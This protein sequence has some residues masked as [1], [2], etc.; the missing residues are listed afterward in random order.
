MVLVA[1]G[2]STLLSCAEVEPQKEVGAGPDADTDADTD[3][4]TDVDTDTDGDT[5]TDTDGDTDSDTDG[6]TDTDTDT[7]PTTCIDEGDCGGDPCVDGF[8]CDGPCDGACQACDLEGF[9]GVCSFV[10][11]G[12]DPDDE[13]LEED[14]STCGTSGACDG[15]GACAFWGSETACDDEEPCTEDDACDGEGGC[16]GLTPAECDP[17]P[18]NECCEG[19]CSSISGCY[20]EV[21]E[22]VDV[23][24]SSALIVSQ[25]CVGCGAANAEGVCTGGTNYPCSSSSHTLCQERD[26]GGATYYCT[27]DGGTWGWRTAVACDDGDDCTYSDSCFGG[28][29]VSTAYTCDSDDCMDREC[30]GSGGC[31]ETP[32]ADTVECGTTSCPGDECSDGD[33][34]DYGEQCTNHCDGIGGCETCVCTPGETECLVGFS[35]ECCEVACSATGGCYTVAGSCGGGDIC[36]DSNTLIVGS[37]CTGCG[38]NGASGTCGGG[39]S[40]E[41]SAAT[42]TACE[43]VSC[44]GTTY[45]C[46]NVGG[47]WQWRSATSCDDGDPCTHGDVC[48]A[49]GCAGTGITC[50]DTVCMDRECNGTSSCTETPLPSSTECGTTA[51]PGDSCGVG[52]WYDYPSE[53]TSYCDGSGACDYCTCSSSATTCEVGSSNECCQVTCDAALGCGTT[54]GSCA[55]TDVCTDSNTLVYGNTCVGCGLNGANGV[56]GSGTTAT[57]NSTTH[58]LCQEVSCGG[59]NYYCTNVGGIWQWRISSSCDDSNLC[60]YSD[61]CG[62]T[63]ICS[64]TSITCADSS[65]GCVVRSCNGGSSC[66]QTFPSGNACV[67]SDLCTYDT[68]C[69]GAGVCAGG[70]TVDCDALDTQ[71]ADYF[72]DGDS[73]CAVS[74]LSGACDDTDPCTYGETCDGSGSCGGGTTVD[75]D[76]L[77]WECEDYSCDGDSTCDVSVINIGGICDDGDPTTTGDACQPDGTCLG[78]PDCPTTLTSVFSDHFSSPSSSSW[79]DGSNVAVSSSYWNAYT[80]SYHGVRIY[81]GQMQITNKTGYSGPSHG[82]GYAYVKTG[83]TGSDYDNTYYDSI[84]GDNSG[85]EVVWSFNMRRDDPESTDGGFSCDSTS[86]QNDRTVGLAYV[87]AWRSSPD[88]LNASTSTC[89]SSSSGEGYAVV[90]GGS[91]GAVRLVRFSGGLRNGNITNIVSSGGYSPYRYFSVRVTYNADTNLW[92]LEARSDGSSFSDPAS[93]TYG[94]NSTGTDST[95]TSQSLE[96]SGAYFQ[97][98]CTGLCDSTYTALFD[99]VDVGIRCAP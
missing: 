78:E 21:G 18:A 30:D 47:V 54:E 19:A 84:L 77:D 74:Y 80:T 59:A 50:A 85:M 8:C 95:Y 15:A 96:Y 17:G 29:C 66:T 26:C 69:N 45:Y 57:C 7:D 56:C 40:F 34:L 76:S 43:D 92:R 11:D 23:C 25:T 64:G 46:T 61:V 10:A 79:S 86:S 70:T 36:T 39:G 44:G 60:T 49:T 33:W 94:F 9:E 62:G 6:D 2:V 4:D 72:C 52:E 81:N 91:S 51:C 67:D 16:E 32:M 12:D 75:C 24:D 89:D 71:C 53:C 97:T 14:P 90:M 93:G 68:T 65:D 38:L 83:G 1:A 58:T 22:C 41:C 28:T 3:T 55:G 48:G 31:V 63:G 35:N 82:H 37:V 20:T 27:N 73:T 99:N 5:D 87:L 98:G 13:C 88:G 42:H